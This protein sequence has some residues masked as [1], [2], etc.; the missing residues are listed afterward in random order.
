MKYFSLC[1]MLV[2]LSTSAV[3]ETNLSFDWPQWQGPDRNAISKET[4][5]LK[6]WPEGGPRLV[7]SNEEIGG[8]YSAPSVADGQM[9][10]MSNRG[11]DEFVWCLSE[12]DGKEIWATRLG[13]AVTEGGSQGSEGPGCTPTVDGERI[14]VIGAGGTVACLQIADGKLVW[15]KNLQ[16]DFGG[17]IP[18][19]RY[20]ESPLIDG[21]K[22]ICTPGGN[23]ASIVALNKTNG[24]TIWETAV[25]PEAADKESSDAGHSS[26]NRGGADN[27]GGRGGRR[28]RGPSSGAGY[29]SAIAIDAAG[30]RQY[31]QFTAKT[32]VGVDA[33]DGRV[34]WRYDSPANGMGISCSTPLYHDGLIFAASAYGAGGGAIRLRKEA[35]GTIAVDEA[36]F[37]TKMQNHHGGVIVVDGSL[38]GTNGGN[39]G[40]LLTCLDFETGDVLWQDRE[41]PKGALTL[42]DDRLYLYTEDGTMMLI[43]PNRDKLVVHG[44]FQHP[45]RSKST[46]WTH[47]VI[48][49]GK[50]YV[51]DQSRLFCYDVKAK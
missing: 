8:G 25:T 11:V 37:T 36:Y 29:S 28:S 19:W 13:P 42:A 30:Q 45:G 7:W 39:G 33:N 31:V 5:L 50:L 14:Y 9:F 4:G 27:R 24:A 49:N 23:T 2:S 6:Q 40:G 20:N 51:R 43:E 46:A 12:T 47:P 32:L 21:E 1:L 17:V 16:D 48:V 10:G 44:R 26:D 41:A 38:Y 22:I 34:L 15:K 35:D 3:A 18:R